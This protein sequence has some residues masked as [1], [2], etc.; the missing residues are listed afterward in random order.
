[1][2]AELKTK[3]TT[4]DP[5]DFIATVEPPGKRADAEVL[6]GIFRRATGVDPYMWG[7][8]ILG[9]G[10]YHYR[11]ASGHEGDAP[12]VGFSPRKAK[13]SLYLLGC[14]GEGADARFEEYLARL[15]K[16]SRAVA[17]LY[18]NKLADIDLSVLEEMVALSWNQS[19][20]DWPES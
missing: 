12:R 7:G 3:P 2:M 20:K 10:S 18:V 15:G 17:C 14:G 13:H 6:D 1:M 19:F 5:A 8:T 11:Y 4:V 9:Y 16:H